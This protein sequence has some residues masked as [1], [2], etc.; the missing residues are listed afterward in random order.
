M[1]KINNL[2]CLLVL[3]CLSTG[4]VSCEKQ[5]KVHNTLGLMTTD[6]YFSDENFT[7]ILRFTACSDVHYGNTR[8]ALS[9]IITRMIDYTNELSANSSYK[10]LDATIVAGDISDLGSPKV[11]ETFRDELNNAKNAETMPLVIMGNHD[12]RGGVDAEAN[13]AE[14]FGVPTDRH[15]VINGFHFICLSPSNQTSFS[16]EKVQWLDNELAIASAADPTKPIFVAQH[17]NISNTVVGSDNW[18]VP[19]LT[20]TLE[21]YPQVIDFSGH[22]HFPMK[23]TRS[24]HQSSFTSLGCG[25]MYYYE[26]GISGYK[27]DGCFPTDEF[28]SYE[29]TAAHSLSG[30]DYYIVEADANNAV[31]ITGIDLLT[32]TKIC[33]YGI[34]EPSN[35]DSFEYTSTKKKASA[36]KPFFEENHPVTAKVYQDRIILHIKQAYCKDLIESYRI[37]VFKDDKKVNNFYALSGYY[38][39]PMPEEVY[40]T[41]SN[42]ESGTTYRID[43]YAITT[44]GLQND[45][46]LSYEISTL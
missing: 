46:P 22:S 38:M 31:R 40:A 19:E 8:G 23:D 10:N 34:K 33:Q 42:L 14:V 35:K 29:L 15:E 26:L 27:E 6:S 45:K 11:W 7:P 1:K 25:T 16:D 44:L 3:T 41:L 13:F 32:K 5:E 30:A 24:I 4:L 21:K 36:S 28:G 9:N 18:G 43:I 12:F 39:N 17:F 2:F 37:E 20:S